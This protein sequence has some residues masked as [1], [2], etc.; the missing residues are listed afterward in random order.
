MGVTNRTCSLQTQGSK[1]QL[2]LDGSAMHSWVF[3]DD[4]TLRFNNHN[5]PM[6]PEKEKYCK[7][8]RKCGKAL[9]YEA[10]AHF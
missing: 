4:F 6:F 5:K 1:Q 8:L 3:I 7:N 2:Q 9:L 10:S